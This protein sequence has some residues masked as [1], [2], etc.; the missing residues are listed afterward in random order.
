[1]PDLHWYFAFNLFRLA[2]IVQGVKRRMLDGNVSSAAAE[3]TVAQLIPLSATF[4]SAQPFPESRV[5]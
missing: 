2:S 5:V 4:L 3:K 1:M